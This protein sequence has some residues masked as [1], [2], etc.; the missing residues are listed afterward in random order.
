MR[1][2]GDL[3]FTIWRQQDD[4]LTLTERLSLCIVQNLRFL[5]KTDMIV[6]KT[7]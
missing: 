3:A 7:R 1:Q 6:P 4:R 2:L 5:P